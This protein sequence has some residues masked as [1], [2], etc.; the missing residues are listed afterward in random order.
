M[1]KLKPEAVTHVGIAVL[2]LEKAISDYSALF[3]FDKVER[4]EV[5]T[6]GVKVAMLSCGSSEIELLCPTREEGA[7]AKFV[8]EKGEGIHHM[9]IRVPDVGDAI[10]QARKLGLSVLDE[11]PRVGA[12]GAEAAFIHPKSFHGVLLEFYNR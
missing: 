1:S 8:R 4:M 5:G 3:D 2:D 11:K 9:A 6:E 10:E 7:I 12:R